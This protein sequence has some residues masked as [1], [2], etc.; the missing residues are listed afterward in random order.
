MKKTT[1]S[2]TVPSGRNLR[3]EAEQIVDLLAIMGDSSDNIPGLSQDLDLKQPSLCFK[4][5]VRLKSFE[6]S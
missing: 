1:F 4:N 3:V 6:A 2:S 5:L